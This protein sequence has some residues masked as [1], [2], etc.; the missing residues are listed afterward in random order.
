MEQIKLFQ[1]SIRD[2]LEAQVNYF[3]S[4]NE[5]KISVKDI[6]FN[7]VAKVRQN[8]DALVI[9]TAMVRYEVL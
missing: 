1:S 5:T 2:E 3:L 6:Q 4:E 8:Y 9:W 7:T